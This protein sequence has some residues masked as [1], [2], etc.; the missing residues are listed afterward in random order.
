MKLPSSF[1]SISV[2]IVSSLVSSLG[3]VSYNNQKKILVT[4]YNVASTPASESDLRNLLNLPQ[5]PK[6]LP[7]IVAMG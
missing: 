6:D 2:V 5:D 4:T 1:L 7:D 3:N